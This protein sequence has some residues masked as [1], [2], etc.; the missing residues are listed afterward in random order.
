MGGR[1][2][3]HGSL[4]QCSV[5]GIPRIGPPAETRARPDLIRSIPDNFQNDTDKLR[6]V[7]LFHFTQDQ[8]LNSPQNL[9]YSATILEITYG[10]CPTGLNLFYFLSGVF[11][12]RQWEK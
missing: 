12:F 10:L 5:D 3:G 6:T 2:G 1:R 9:C 11:G 4:L 7:F 8:N